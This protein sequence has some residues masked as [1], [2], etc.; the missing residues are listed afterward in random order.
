MKERVTSFHENFFLLKIIFSK[1]KKKLGGLAPCAK[2][3]KKSQK[4]Q[5]TKWHLK[6]VIFLLLEI[7]LKNFLGKQLG[8]NFGR[9]SFMG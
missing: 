2:M 8:K 3:A 5:A 7:Q 6:F 9:L 4:L 1:K